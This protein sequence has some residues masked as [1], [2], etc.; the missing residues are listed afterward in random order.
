MAD[1]GADLVEIDHK[2][3]LKTAKQLIGD[4]VC[5]IGILDP[6]A[7]LLYGTPERVAEASQQCIDDAGR[8]GAFILGSGCEVAYYTPQENMKAMIA[9]ARRNRY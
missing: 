3:S 9:T 5:L 8:G 4:R 1:S 6:S 2:V 7:V